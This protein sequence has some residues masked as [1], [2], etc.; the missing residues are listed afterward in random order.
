MK[1]SYARRL[2]ESTNERG[3]LQDCEKELQHCLDVFQVCRIYAVTRCTK[4]KIK[5]KKIRSHIITSVALR[6]KDTADEAFADQVASVLLPV[7]NRLAEPVSKSVEN[8]EVFANS[9]LT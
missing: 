2:V 9:K 6:R 5:I 8:L 3:L 7:K 1:R 4:T